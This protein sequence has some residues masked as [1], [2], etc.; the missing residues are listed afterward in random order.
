MCYNYGVVINMET[1]KAKPLN[2]AE[3]LRKKDGR[4]NWSAVGKKSKNKGNRYEAL[5]AKQL[6]TWYYYEESQRLGAQV[7][8]RTP[9]SGG[10]CKTGDVMIDP[11][12]SK[13]VPDFPFQAEMKRHEN[14]HLEHLLTSD[15]C[16]FRAEWWPK[17][18]EE[19]DAVEKR[20]LLVFAMNAVSSMCAYRI[21]GPMNFNAPVMDIYLPGETIRVVPFAA[22]LTLP[23][24][25]FPP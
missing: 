2:I 5:I 15:K 25:T 12:F 11:R 18:C 6:N 9:L 22:F 1:Q 14:W 3:L 24:G 7:L 23:K 8:R 20:P 21:E 13:E 19:A 16:L 17:L 10:W 4:T